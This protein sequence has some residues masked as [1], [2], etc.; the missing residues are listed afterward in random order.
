MEAGQTV[1]GAMLIVYAII[2]D[3][4]DGWIARRWNQASKW[5]KILD[6]I[7]D[8]MAALVVGLFCVMHRE[9]PL[10]ALALTVARDVALLVGGFVILRRIRA[11][12]TSAD[13]GRYAALL[14]GIVLLLY[15]FDWQPYG[16]VT[17]WPAVA[18]YL[19]AGL[20]YLRRT[21]TAKPT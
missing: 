16:R 2:S 1:W 20:F 13:L 3:V 12:P 15:A 21:L 10:A 14:W 11:V 9:L 4:A 7:G 17:L 5:G 6:P 19:L 18:L 8:K